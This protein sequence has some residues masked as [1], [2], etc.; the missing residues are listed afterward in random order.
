MADAA[1]L[2]EMVTIQRS[3]TFALVALNLMVY[4]HEARLAPGAE[5][6]FGRQ[7]ALSLAG[8]RAGAWWQFLTYQ[9]L[10]GGFAHL[11]LNIL[12]LDSIGPV[13][14]TTLGRWR[15]LV[16]YL[17]SGA[18]GGLVQLLGGALSQKYFGHPVVGASA[19]L[20]GLLAALGAIYAED[21]IQAR[22]LFVIPVT[23]K[24]KYLLLAAGLISIGGVIFPLGNVAHL[25]HLGGLVGGLWC[26]NWLKPQQLLEI[27][28]DPSVPPSNPVNRA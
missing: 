5:Y 4:I 6:E 28:D 8:V 14:E 21:R 10:H 2:P 9:F 11:I 12:F 19:G 25:A 3:A 15:F 1:P 7:F 13:L 18:L 20:C 23:L 16:L 26:V 27:G 24:A 22:I 17:V